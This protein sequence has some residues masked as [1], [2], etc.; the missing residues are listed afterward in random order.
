MPKFKTAI[1]QVEGMKATGIDVPE[2]IVE[3]LGAGK[4]PK[5]TVTLKS[6]TYRSTVFFMGGKFMLPLALEHRNAA[7]VKGGDKVEVRLEL[8]TA[9][10]E[11]EVPKDLAAALKKAGLTKDFAAMAFTHRKEHVRA[12]EEAKAPETR[13]RRIEKA[14]AMVA[15]KK[16]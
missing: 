9:P 10:R 11:V 12:I 3:K 5:V 16:K 15:A 2:A 1:T 14:V 8:D 6:Y 13:L 4:K 7:G